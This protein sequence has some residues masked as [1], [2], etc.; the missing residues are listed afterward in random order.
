MK[1]DRNVRVDCLSAA[2]QALG[3][4]NWRA[5]PEQENQFVCSFIYFS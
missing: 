4:V 3:R 2:I 1:A 5:T